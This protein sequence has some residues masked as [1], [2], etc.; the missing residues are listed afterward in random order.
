MSEKTISDRELVEASPFLAYLVGEGSWKEAPETDFEDDADTP[1]IRDF[2]RSFKKMLSDPETA[3]LALKRLRIRTLLGVAKA[4]LNDNIKPHQI[5]ARL[6][7]LSEVMV[8]GSWWVAE[9]ALR[10]KYVHPLILERKNINPPMAVFSLS[11][12][13]AGE[14][15]YTTGPAPIFVHSRA[16]EFAP[17]LTE[18]DFLSAKKSDKEW[19]PAREYFNRLARRTMSYLSAPDMT[20]K[21]FGQMAEDVT[22]ESLPILPGALVVLFSAFEEHFSGKRPVKEKLSLMRLRF[23]VGQDR[24]GRAVE[25]IARE[26]LAKTALELGS[27]LNAGVNAWYRERAQAEGMPLVKGGLLDIERRL[28]ILQFKYTVEKPDFWEPSPLKAIEKMATEGFIGGDERLTLARS[29]S[30]QWFVANRMSLLGRRTADEWDLLKAGALDEQLGLP[31]AGD[32]M[33]RYMRDANSAL[34]D[35]TREK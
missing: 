24:L 16:A 35:L 19:L 14:P 17:A 3:I 20:G 27:R 22:G 8:Q 34:Y 1:S 18:K 23:L 15:W 7:T 26:T 25:A 10:E 29:Y 13:G 9:A 33:V 32:K 4:D 12:L 31:G 30:F 5:R 11:R 21:G 2:R 28:R 6:R